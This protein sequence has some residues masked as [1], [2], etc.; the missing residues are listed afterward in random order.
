MYRHEVSTPLADVELWALILWIAS[1]AYMELYLTLA[2]FVRR[3]D[4]ELHDTTPEDLR[5]T[6]DLGIGFTRR[7]DMQ[8]YAKVTGVVEN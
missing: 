3:F 2:S 6:H 8:V 1:L 4:I 7:G 5:F